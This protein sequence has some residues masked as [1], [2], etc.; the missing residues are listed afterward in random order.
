[1]N[2]YVKALMILGVAMALFAGKAA[3]APRDAEQHPVQLVITRAAADLSA[4][5]LIIEGKNFGAAPEVLFGAPGGALQDL[6]AALTAGGS[7][8]APLPTTEPGTYLLIVR[9]GQG[10]TQT[11]TMN[12]TI[13]ATGPEGPRGPKGDTGP[14]GPQGPEGPEGPAGPEGLPGPEGP[15]GPEGP[16]GPQGP[17]GAPGPAGPE[18][19][20]GPEGPQGAEGDTGPAG[21]PGTSS[22]TDGSGTVTTLADVGIG[23]SAPVAALDVAGAAKIGDD[24]G[25]CDSSMAGAIRWNG[26][27]FEGCDGSEWREFTMGGGSG[28]GPGT[29]APSCKAIKDADLE[30][31]SGPYLIDPNGGS[32][33]DAFHA[34]CDM[35]TD[36]GGWTL[37]TNL[38]LHSNDSIYFAAITDYRGIVNYADENL[39][40]GANALNDLR[41]D[42]G[43]TDLR[44]NCHKDYNAKTIDIKTSA[45]P[46]LDYFTART[47]T[48]PAAPSSYTILAADNSHLSQ[49]PH[50][51]GYLYS[52]GY[53]TGTWSTDGYEND[54]RLHNHPFF[55]A[56]TAH[57]LANP[58]ERFECDDY[59]NVS[60]GFWK[61]WVR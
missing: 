60:P 11:A 53:F 58:N 3:T 61:I 31:A 24:A 4:G 48:K 37:V 30:A 6:Q 8:A 14:A 41:N 42:M 40:I 56:W 19:P 25:P 27:A 35:D 22:W 33:A 47:N 21:P 32:E 45:L 44:F 28:P 7:I 29:V 38:V 52:G 17:E 5:T 57:W 23:V 39:A 18:G 20:E 16:E 9:S 15:I 51:W 36:G 55:E 59:L 43:F 26:A 54:Y 12:V 10:A 1:M 50:R 49:V 46:V 13:G 2:K 34:W